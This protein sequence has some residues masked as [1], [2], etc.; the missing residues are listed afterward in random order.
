MR[1]L[2]VISHGDRIQSWFLSPTNAGTPLPTV[3]IVHG[4]PYEAFG[5]CHYGDAHLLVEAGY[6]VVIANPRGSIG[7]GADFA[8]SIF[9]RP[10]MEDFDDLMAV[11][12]AVELGWADGDR[13]A[14]CGL[15]YGG[16]MSAPMAARSDRFRAA[17]IENPRIEMRSFRDTS[18]IGVDLLGEES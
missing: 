11:D 4:G 10:G 14:V 5:H 13:L 9:G 8:T 18:D 12:R 15:S 7:Y 1:P 16:Y 6:G 17:V 3:L 2:D